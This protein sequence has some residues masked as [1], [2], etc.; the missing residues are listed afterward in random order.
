MCPVIEI[1]FV[2]VVSCF[3][4]PMQ[5]FVIPDV[6]VAVDFSK[7]R[8]FWIAPSYCMK[9]DWSFV[10]PNIQRHLECEVC[11]LASK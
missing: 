2:V 5:V 4:L 8:Q 9:E 7:K 6:V 1:E 3:V 10:P 11:P